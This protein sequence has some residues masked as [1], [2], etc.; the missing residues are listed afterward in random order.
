VK[1]LEIVFLL[2]LAVLFAGFLVT[3]WTWVAQD[4]A[5]WK[6]FWEDLEK[7]DREEAIRRLEIQARMF[8]QRS[9]R[10]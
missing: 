2:E 5:N 8:V 10:A 1:P 4:R 6:K 3:I 9:P 7:R